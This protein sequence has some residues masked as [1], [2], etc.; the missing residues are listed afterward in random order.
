MAV[1]MVALYCHVGQEQASDG[2]VECPL[3]AHS[4]QQAVASS[5]LHSYSLSFGV[6]ASGTPFLP[7]SVWQRLYR[8]CGCFF[9]PRDLRITVI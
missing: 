8:P 6:K 1:V 7:M 9:V 2:I 3:T 4:H 5:D